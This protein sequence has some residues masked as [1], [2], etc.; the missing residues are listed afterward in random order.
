MC[1]LLG[2]G[3]LAP[4]LA[5]PPDSMRLAGITYESAGTVSDETVNRRSVIGRVKNDVDTNL[6]R[7]TR[8]RDGDATYLEP[9][10]PVY[11][12]EGYKPSFRVAARSDDRWVLY[13]VV[14]N[15]DAR[16]AEKLLDVAG[17]VKR[18]TVRQEVP[19]ARE[20]TP[21]RQPEETAALVDV[22]LES[23]V[24]WVSR[25]FTRHDFVFEL[26]DDTEVVRRYEP[27][28]GELY[29]SQGETYAGVVL[30]EKY[31][32]DVSEALDSPGS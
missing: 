8:L 17:R 27:R 6:H 19:E 5:A 30:P 10:T 7:E 28:S 24:V 31:R 9:G 22:V 18:V 32:D 4:D 3:C 25:D 29:L 13:G 1:V 26:D 16:S 12:V 15:P 11:A 14:E 23:P 2:S 20:V 21:V